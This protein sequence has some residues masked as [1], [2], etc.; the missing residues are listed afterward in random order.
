M[1]NRKD[2]NKICARK[3]INYSFSIL[4]KDG[5]VKTTTYLNFSGE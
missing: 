1:E 5:F 4:E 2:R 3:I